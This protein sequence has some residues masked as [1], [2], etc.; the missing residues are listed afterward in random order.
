MVWYLGEADQRLHRCLWEDRDG[1]CPRASG[2]VDYRV[3]A[4]I[5]TKAFVGIAQRAF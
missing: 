4:E 2:S 5:D 1:I 3:A